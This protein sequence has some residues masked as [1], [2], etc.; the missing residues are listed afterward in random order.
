MDS[1]EPVAGLRRAWRGELEAARAT[2]TRFLALA[3]ERGEGVSYA[4]LRLNLCELELRAGNWDAAERL[5]DEWAD[6]DDGVLL[7]TPTYQRCRALLAAGRGHAEEAQRWA[8]PALEE[9]AARGYSWQV[10]E[11]SRALGLA[12]LLAHE[13]ARAATYLRAVWQHTEREGVDEPGAFPVAGDLVEALCELGETDEARAVTER[14]RS[15]SGD[16]HPWGE[17]TLRRAEG[18]V[19]HEAEKLAEAAVAYEHLGLRF[20]AARALLAYGRAQRRARQWRAA[21]DAL[22]G[23]AQAFETLGSPGWVGQAKAELTRVGGRRPRAAGELTETERQVAL[24]AAAGRTNKEIAHALFVTV[25]TVEAHLSS[26]YA[27]LG[28]RTRTQLAA[29]L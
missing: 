18:F 17:A 13:P 6:T 19:D 12:A 1:P 29:R 3:A 9:A 23:A 22:E 11:A 8:A 25:H 5:L 14:L 26:T 15:L 28:V 21:R 27:K 24:L 7:I 16:H 4:W 2:T 10:L 20:D